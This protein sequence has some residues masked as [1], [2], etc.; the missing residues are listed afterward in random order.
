MP[1]KNTVTWNEMIHGYAQNG[2]GHNALCLYNDMISSGE[3]PDDITFVAVLTACSHSSLVDEGL[4]ISNAMLRKF[5]VVPLYLSLREL[6][7]N[8]S[9]RKPSFMI[10]A[11][12]NW[13]W[14]K[15][16]SFAQELTMFEEKERQ[17][18]ASVWRKTRHLVQEHWLRTLLTLNSNIHYLLQAVYST[19]A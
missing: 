14:N 9:S 8:M 7:T 11:W 5:G 12:N 2:D 6:P 3:K 15:E 16:E 10:W 19:H 18:L 1:G 17:V 13:P 4:E